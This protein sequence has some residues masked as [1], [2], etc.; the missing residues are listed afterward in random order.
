MNNYKKSIIIFTFIILLVLWEVLCRT[1]VPAYIVASPFEIFSEIYSN[2]DYFLNHLKW[3]FFA[4][5][6]GLI[7]GLL[8]AIMLSICADAWQTTHSIILTLALGAQ[9]TPIIVF[10]PILYLITGPFYSRVFIS[11][12][13]VTIPSLIFV[14][15]AFRTDRAL[16][17]KSLALLNVSYYEKLKLYKLPKALPSLF[18][19]AKLGAANSVI[20]AVV[21]EWL[22][23]EKGLGYIATI[24][25]YKF[26][27]PKLY[28]SVACSLALS[29][30]FYYFILLIEKNIFFVNRY[31]GMRKVQKLNISCN[32]LKHK[33]KFS[34]DLP[35]IT[36]KSNRFSNERDIVLALRS[37]NTELSTDALNHALRLQTPLILSE[38]EKLWL[39]KNKSY[40][41]K[42]KAMLAKLVL[43]SN[44]PLI[45]TSAKD[46]LKNTF[47]GLN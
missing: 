3:T 2:F 21:A 14:L 6:L 31:F 18:A 17:E 27:T 45:R 10:Y 25:L 41:D 34:F 11:A 35:M 26:D 15:Q 43:Q 46:Y 28:S 47:G 39:D 24:S 32:Y 8:S 42:P 20:G 30:C 5:L 1:V 4:A 16:F 29:L 37:D 22:S 7:L 9:S 23:G 40:N 19:S 12:L 38:A 44:N 13:L 36:K 33:S